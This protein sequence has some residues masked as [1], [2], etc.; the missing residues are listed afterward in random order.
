MAVSTISKVAHSSIIDY[1]DYLT[2]DT[3]WNILQSGM[4]SVNTWAGTSTPSNN[5]PTTPGIGICW[6]IENS[7]NIT[8]IVFY[9]NGYSAFRGY[10]K[11]D[12][13]WSDWT[14]MSATRS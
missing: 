5:Y 3:N 6:V 8:Q 7:R 10:T 12:A 1:I 9:S 11:S 2:R 14:E 13:T 4:Y